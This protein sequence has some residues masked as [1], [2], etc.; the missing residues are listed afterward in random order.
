M[1]GGPVEGQPAQQPQAGFRI[2]VDPRL[3][4]RGELGM[5]PGALV[6]RQVV[7]HGFAQQSVPEL[8]RVP[9]PA[10]HVGVEQ[11]AEERVQ[12]HLVDS[13]DLGER[14]GVHPRSVHGRDPHQLT[15]T[16][17]QRVDPGQEQVGQLVGDRSW[18]R[19]RRSPRRRAGCPPTAPARTG[20]APD[21]ACLRHRRHDAG[22]AVPVQGT[23]L[24]ASAP[25][26]PADLGQRLPGRVPAMQ[27]VGPD[28]EH[29]QQSTP[30]GAGQRDGEISGRGVRPVQVLQHQ[31]HRA[32]SG[33]LQ[34]GQAQVLQE[35]ALLHAAR[36]AGSR[37]ARIRRATVET[38]CPRSRPRACVT[39]SITGPNEIP[40]SMSRQWPTATVNPSSSA[41]RARS[42]TSVVLPTPA[43]PATTTTWGS[44]LSAS[45]R[46]SYSSPARAHGRAVPPSRSSRHRCHRL[47]W[48]VRVPRQIIVGASKRIT[49]DSPSIAFPPVV[50]G[51]TGVR[52]IDRSSPR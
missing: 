40:A 45:E 25:R 8:Q 36:V 50:V 9:R 32:R 11:V 16:L 39:A 18:S 3:E 1:R 7:V 17:G 20:P 5:K 47:G 24:D 31:Q 48:C 15:R 27:V 38:R 51:R 23:E 22:D 37:N 4:D 26:D 19:R 52:G 6:G 10:Q 14:V 34:D 44:P 43:S 28:G 30:C 12:P 49:H 29:E 33:G 13:R 21:R 46:A 2:R 35:V 42:A 41:R